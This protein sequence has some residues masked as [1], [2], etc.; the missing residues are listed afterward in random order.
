VSDPDFNNLPPGL[1]DFLKTAKQLNQASDAVNASLK[2]VE[3]LLNASNVGV[4]FWFDAKP[5]SQSDTT[6]DLHPNALSEYF[7]DVLG[8]ARVDGKWCFAAK[9][10]RYVMGYYEGEVRM[11]FTNVYA[12]G[13]P[14]AL[15][16]ASRELRLAALR[17]MPEFLE[18]FRETIAQTVGQIEAATGKLAW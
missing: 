17:T 11:P 9:R 7:T 12:A 2:T 6:G 18:A 1:E 13:E 16:R 4:T 8:Y 14:Q 15:L 10:L 3:E 5:L